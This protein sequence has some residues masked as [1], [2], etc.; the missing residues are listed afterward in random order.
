MTHTITIGTD[1]N[2]RKITSSIPDTTEI[3]ELKCI[4]KVND[5]NYIAENKMTV[6]GQ[7]GEC[8]VGYYRFLNGDTIE[9]SIFYLKNSSG[10]VTNLANFTLPDD[11]GVVTEIDDTSVLY[12]YLSR[13]TREKVYVIGEDYS[14]EESLGKNDIR[15]EIETKVRGYGVPINSVMGF[16]G[17]ADQ[18]PPGFEYCEETIGG[19][20]ASGDTLPIGSMI[21]YGN[22]TAP[23]NWLIC[24]GSAISRTEYAELYAVIGTSYGAGDGSTTFN[25]PDKRGRTSAGFDSTNTNFNSIG[26]H[27]GEE[28][29]TLTVAEMPNHTHNVAAEYGNEINSYLK[30]GQT[31]GET[32]GKYYNIST[33]TGGGQPHNNLQPTEVDNWIIKAFQSAGVLATI[34]QEKTNSDTDAYS[35]NYIN[36]VNKKHVLSATLIETI[37]PTVK[38]YVEISTF[39]EV[40]KIGDKLSIENGKIK[41]GANV[42]HIKIS[43]VLGINTA[44]AGL[45]YMWTKKNGNNI[46]TWQVQTIPASYWQFNVEQ[47]IN[48]KENDIISLSM[49]REGSYNL[50]DTKTIVIFEVID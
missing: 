36:E 39:E 4:A 43:G 48:V 21:P 42:N 20:Q 47:L 24:D 16:K 44:N 29:H 31:S 22:V 26:K 33:P 2:N 25:L 34:A 10:I 17:T 9:T 12:E 27:I 30:W 45:V 1:L 46:G 23:T 3:S 41:I 8:S 11:F 15:N 28:T 40:Y 13:N 32:T 5:N 37:T 35:C 18:I 49:Y 6:E 38:Q 14:K 50:E 19:G 7:I